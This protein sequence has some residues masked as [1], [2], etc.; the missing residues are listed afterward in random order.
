MI[1]PCGSVIL[2]MPAGHM[3]DLRYYFM[4][5]NKVRITWDTWTTRETRVITHKELEFLLQFETK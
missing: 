4:V 3:V 5:N 2:A 1:D